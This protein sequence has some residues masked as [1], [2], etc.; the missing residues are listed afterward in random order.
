MSGGMT[1]RQVQLI[2]DFKPDII[3]VTPSYML[4]IADEFD[5]HGWSYYRRG[6]F[7]LFFAGFWM[8]G[9]RPVLVALA[10]ALLVGGSAQAQTKVKTKTKSDA[11]SVTA[12]S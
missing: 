2:T 8:K 7:D 11:A 6:R 5:K 9:W 3:M 4:A 12:S 1:E 10:A